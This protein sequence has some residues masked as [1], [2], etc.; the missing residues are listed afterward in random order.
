MVAACGGLDQ[1][2]K[3][4]LPLAAGIGCTLA[5]MGNQPHG[6]LSTRAEP[7]RDTL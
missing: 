7:G 1:I 5:G 4:K 3:D 6:P 2:R